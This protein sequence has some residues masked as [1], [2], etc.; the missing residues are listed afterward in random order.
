MDSIV[1]TEA[2]RTFEVEDILFSQL[3]V[4]AWKR[5]TIVVARTNNRNDD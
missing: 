1:V 2:R 3:V 5:S 4:V